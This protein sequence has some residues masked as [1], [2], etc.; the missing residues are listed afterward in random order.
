MH[1]LLWEWR[2]RGRRQSLAGGK[3]ME[4]RIGLLRIIVAS[5]QL[6]CDQGEARQLWI[7]DEIV[8]YLGS[9]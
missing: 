7:R 1:N 9:A 3:G 2:D 4:V 5:T 6:G 8:S